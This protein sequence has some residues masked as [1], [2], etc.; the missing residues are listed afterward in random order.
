MS[1]ELF[2]VGGKATHSQRCQRR[3]RLRE[4]AREA[5]RALAGTRPHRPSTFIEKFNRS[6]ENSRSL[7]RSRVCAGQPMRS[8][9]RRLATTYASDRRGRSGR[10][11]E[12]LATAGNHRS[13]RGDQG[14]VPA[15]HGSE[16]SE[17][18]FVGA[19]M[20]GADLAAEMAE[21]RGRIDL[22]A[23]AAPV[24]NL[25]AQTAIEG[26]YAN[27]RNDPRTAAIFSKLEPKLREFIQ[28]TSPADV[29]KMVA[30]G[31]LMKE[32]RRRIQDCPGG[33]V[34]RKLRC[35]GRRRQASAP[36]LHRIHRPT[37]R[38]RAAAHRR[39]CRVTSSL[40]MPPTLRG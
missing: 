25:N 35:S 34:H 32:P 14:P 38:E 7:N 19:Q 31:S 37:A 16:G 23:A 24:L 9:I 4:A 22:E 12:L 26:F 6:R 20:L 33:F 27:K 21:A 5:L 11:A 39:Y 2:P 3:L 10:R 29:A 15:A 18:D 8:R 36:A 13:D 40:M 30:N 1:D 17:G 28:R